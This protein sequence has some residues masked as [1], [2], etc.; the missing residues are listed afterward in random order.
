M[1]V[2]IAIALSKLRTNH[3]TVPGKVVT[4]L[5]GETQGE[6][7][8]VASTTTDTTSSPCSFI[9]MT[10]IHRIFNAYIYVDFLNLQFSKY[11]PNM[12]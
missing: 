3:R 6:V 10:F 7:H 8:L 11:D 5:Q 9:A 12:Q 1:A 4:L 2:P